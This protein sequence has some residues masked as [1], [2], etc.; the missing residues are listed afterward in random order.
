MLVIFAKS[1]I[2]TSSKFFSPQKI[3]L[4]ERLL[5]FITR[6]NYN[7]V[8]YLNLKS[9]VRYLMLFKFGHITN[10]FFYCPLII[11]LWPK[12]YIT[13]DR[14]I[15]IV[16]WFLSSNAY[17]KIILILNYREKVHWHRIISVSTFFKTIF[18]LYPSSPHFIHTLPCPLSLDLKY[19]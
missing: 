5:V 13:I 9:Q 12:P 1:T 16:V 3:T 18:P 7:W 14:F 4:I 19:T 15:I 6:L 17:S 10:D 8:I 2:S 11:I